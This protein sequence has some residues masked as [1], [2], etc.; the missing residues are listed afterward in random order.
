M[1]PTRPTRR[2][3][4]GHAA[5]AA[6]A[7]IAAPYVKTAH[8]AGSL[9][10]G[11][12]DHWIPGA[13]DV[14]EQVCLEWGAANNV[15]VRVDFITSIGNK[16]LLT[17]QAESRAGTGHDVYS[18][19][20]WMPSIFR[21][22][23]AP[24]DDVIAE[25]GARHG[26]FVP[27][28][29]FLARL[30]GVWRAVPAPNGAPTYATVS[31]LDLFREHAGLDLRAMFPGGPERDPALTATWTW[32]RFLAAAT[33]LH[34]ADAPFGAPVSP[35]PDGNQWLATVFSSYGATLID[36]NDDI[37]VDSEATR[38]ALDYMSRLTA[39]MDPGIYAWDDAG[40]NRWI[41]SG[42][43]SSIFN[44]PSAWA[45]ALRDN[46]EVGRQLWHH[47]APAGPAG[48]YRAGGVF[49]WGAWDFSPNIAAAKDLFLHVNERAVVDRVVRASQG[50]DLPTIQS[51]YEG[52]DIWTTA[53]PPEGVL[54][55]YPVRGD[56]VQMAVGYPARPEI[57][58]AI[59]T[60]GVY[61]NFVARVTQ[62]G[63]S[64]DDAIAWAEN[65]LEG[66]LFI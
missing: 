16:L 27:S 40:N 44:P 57:A 14:M 30:D 13:N 28:V 24:V 6:A 31:R 3:F 65:E 19:P 53:G 45:V 4:L 51:F 8:S 46:P 49:F 62:G 52:N 64:L 58:A 41:I 2:R 11:L 48:R 63:E 37:V 34:A 47:D 10:L 42:R 54:Y 36:E 26:P 43:G 32:E 66:L 15:E 20:T 22:R 33:A 12:W 29:E 9:A 17:A 50:Y 56:E 25:I 38:E 1:A 61:A 39:V 18:L 21:R 5:A 35:T 60:Q 7:G 59:S 23:L 55:N